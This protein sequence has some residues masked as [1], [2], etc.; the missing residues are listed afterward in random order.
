[1][2]R[3]TNPAIDIGSSKDACFYYPR[4]PLTEIDALDHPCPL[5]FIVFL[6]SLSIQ[7]LFFTPFSLTAIFLVKT[8]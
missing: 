4:L 7:N 2:S 8:G 3:R 5:G 6:V 1:M